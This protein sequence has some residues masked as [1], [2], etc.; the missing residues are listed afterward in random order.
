MSNLDISNFT[1]LITEDFPIYA[2]LLPGVSTADF[3]TT[4]LKWKITRV[5]GAMDVVAQATT[6]SANAVGV[7]N[8]TMEIDDLTQV[9]S[10]S[11]TVE[12]VGSGIS[13]TNSEFVGISS[14]EAFAQTIDARVTTANTG[15]APLFIRATSASGVTSSSPDTVVQVTAFLDTQGGTNGVLDADEWYTTVTITLKGSAG[16]A[17]T[18]SLASMTDGDTYVTASATL[19]GMNWS[20]LNGKPFLALT[21][22]HATNYFS[23]STAAA[24]GSV[25]SSAITGT[26]ATNRAGVVT[27]SFT[28][29]AASES[30][31]VTLTLRYVEDG[32][33][34]NAASGVALGASLTV[35]VG[36]PGADTVSISSVVS[37]NNIAGGGV[38]Y[39]VRQ[40]QTVTV[41]LYAL[42]NSASVSGQAITVTTGGN[43]GLVTSSR[44]LSVDGVLKTT[45]PTFTVTT[46]ANGFASFT[47]A[48]SGYVNA[49]TITIDASVGNVSAPTVTLTVDDPDYT[50]A[51]A[52]ST[53]LTAPG[54]AVNLDLT[55]EDQYGAAYVGT[56]GYIKLTRNASTG[57]APAVT[58]SYHAIVAGAATVAYTPE[59]A[60]ATG[61]SSLTADFVRMINGAYVD[62]GTEVA[63]SVNVSSTARSFGL[64]LAAS[65]SAHVSYWPATV[66]W[67]TVTA[68]VANTG[69]AVVVS[70]D[71]SLIF[72]ASAALPTTTSGGITVR[73]S[74]ALEYTFQVSAPL[75]GNHT[76]TMTNGTATTTSL[77]VVAAAPYTSGAT[78][79]FDTSAITAG[80]T[81]IVTGTLKDM[82]GNP[83][84]TAGTASMVVTYAGTAGIPVGSM[85]TATDVNG[86]FVVSILTSAADD[87]DF[88]LTATYMKNGASTVLA[89]RITKVQT[90]TVGTAAAAS[91]DAK[92][93]AGSF[94]GYVAVY[95]K[96]YKG[97]RLSAKVGNDWVVVESLASNFERVVEFTGA[98]YTIAVR[99]YI[100]RVLV[101]TI[102][103]TTK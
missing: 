44:T 103:V 17:P 65:Y 14:T 33:A 48:P 60:T 34:T 73:A 56:D 55:V 78:I 62:S 12:T 28:T 8:Y 84:Y 45:H 59:S 83:V 77:L 99:I 27:E 37:T 96:G 52:Y 18:L 69:S 91:T 39:T 97:Q 41:T 35:M 79:T 43:V 86:N 61:S 67:T 31:Y 81:K 47:L 82:N 71:S 15:I 54:T 92:V 4:T 49:N 2:E 13:A 20:N 72:R 58:V 7:G 70:G 22:S 19:A 95:A 93:N 90:I 29:A 3:D 9:G 53:L 42:S 80:K 64:G 102:T 1:G 101:D 10:T 88:T 36:A 76:L 26:Q 98:G 100:D 68:K 46:D 25:T 63:I 51:A 24:D 85:P 23:K 6:V 94:K 40:N 5:S 89:D 16:L 74:G 75:T 32:T 30:K 57:F 87:G 38:A 11:S 21:S 50:V 66:S